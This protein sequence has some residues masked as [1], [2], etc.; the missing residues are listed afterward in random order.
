MTGIAQQLAQ[1]QLS[2][3]DQPSYMPYLSVEDQYQAFQK[4]I[5]THAKFETDQNFEKKFWQDLQSQGNLPLQYDQATIQRE[6]PTMAI[7]KPWTFHG[8]IDALW[9][10]DQTE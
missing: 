1:G 4:G 10:K 2:T 5:A 6:L 7:F 9:S 8:T 3:A